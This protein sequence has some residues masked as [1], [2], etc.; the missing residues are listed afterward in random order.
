MCELEFHFYTVKTP[1]TGTPSHVVY[2]CLFHKE[3]PNFFREWLYNFTLIPTKS[4]SSSLSESLPTLR[5]ISFVFILSHSNKCVA[6]P[7]SFNLHFPDDKYT[8]EHSCMYLFGT[9]VSLVKY[10]SKSCA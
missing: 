3:L 9:Y 1:R 10:L 8:F 6:I 4:Q 7:C 2:V 5:S